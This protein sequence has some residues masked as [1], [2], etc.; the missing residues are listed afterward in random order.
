M[1]YLRRSP[2]ADLALAPG[3]GGSRFGW[4]L[5]STP[6]EGQRAPQLFR[7]APAGSTS[8]SSS[9]RPQRCD[10]AGGV[11]PRLRTHTAHPN[12][13][14]RDCCP[15]QQVLSVDNWTQ[16][17][18]LRSETLQQAV[19]TKVWGAELSAQRHTCEVTELQQ[20]PQ[21]SEPGM[22]GKQRRGV[23]PPTALGPSRS[24]DTYDRDGKIA[25][26]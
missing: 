11:P 18:I 13:C 2:G 21:P 3:K 4:E 24:Q 12:K 8:N 9:P 10:R 17:A 25:L 19:C 22:R 23:G 16:P 14:R 6:T 20:R 5:P 26:Q 1:R 7:G 15:V